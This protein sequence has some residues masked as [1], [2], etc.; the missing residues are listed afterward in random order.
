[1]KALI[2]KEERCYTLPGS[3]RPLRSSSSRGIRK[4]SS[5]WPPL[6]TGPWVRP[7]MSKSAFIS[8]AWL[9]HNVPLWTLS[10][11]FTSL[12]IVSWCSFWMIFS[13]FL[14]SLLKLSLYW[15]FF[16]FPTSS[17]SP[18]PTSTIPFCCDTFFH[19]LVLI[20]PIYLLIRDTTFPYYSARFHFFQ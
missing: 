19:T 20:P 14:V 15:I 3:S 8:C 5:C 6:T 12:L 13:A 2:P 7:Q 18:S 9:V 10:S 11:S 16:T 17:T 1:M 4:L